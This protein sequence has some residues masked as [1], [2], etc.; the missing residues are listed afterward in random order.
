M[1]SAI[2]NGPRFGF[3]DCRELVDLN[4]RLPI[5]VG[6]IAFKFAIRFQQEVEVVNPDALQLR[7]RQ[8]GANDVSVFTQH[9][10][11]GK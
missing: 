6:K 1:Q 5:E 3:I 8:Q 2:V 10:E 7:G 4:Q 9:D 11:H